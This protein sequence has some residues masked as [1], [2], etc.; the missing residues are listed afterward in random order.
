MLIS[1]DSITKYHNVKEIVK[2]ASLTIEEH[3]KTALIGVN[4][5][6][7]TTILRIVA[8]LESY[9]GNIVRKNGLRI[10][11]LPQDPVFDEQESILYQ[12]MRVDPKIEEYEAKSIL[13][14]LGMHDVDLCIA[15]LSGGQRKR[16]ALARALL[17][18]CDLLILDE[19]TNHLDNEMIEWLE[20]YLKRFSNAI[21]MV[22]HD[23]Y[24]LE[25]VCT[26]MVEISQGKLY[27]YEANY[28][29]YLEAKALREE[30]ALANEKKRQNLLRKELAWIRAGVQAR[31]TKSKERIE[32]FHALNAQDKLQLEKSIALD[33]TTS[34]LGKKIIELEHISKAYGERVLF[35][36]FSYHFTRHDRIG[37]L[38]AN[39]CGKTTL[40]HVMA[41]QLEPDS[42]TVVHGE[43][44]KLAYFKQGHGDMDGSMK[45]IDYIQE[46][47]NHIE[48]TQ[49]SY[50][51]ASMLERFLFPRS[52]HH[53]TIERLSGG[54]KR[55][56]YL[57]KV[58]MQAP[59]VLF[60]D[61]PTNDLDIATL[62]ILE[63]YLDEFNGAVVVV[64]HDRYFLDRIC[65]KLFVFQNGNIVQHIGG[66]SSF[67]QIASQT[68]ETTPKSTQPKAAVLMKMTT[69]EKQ[70]LAGMETAMDQVQK[71]IDAIDQDMEKYADDFQ[72]L[73]EL[74]IQREA[75]EKQLEEMMERWLQL[76][77]KKARI[78]AMLNK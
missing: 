18:P 70:E 41:K 25:R 31:G 51:A 4:G 57:L 10:S 52:M 40:L 9:E 62:Q 66:Y 37:I 63:D 43:T 53:T 11:Y 61:E 23:R 38:G 21:F 19:P 59:N 71:C 50:T 39:G 72:K 45:L 47:S 64:S 2:E 75:K 32:R 54:E 1:M 5:A 44:L 77:D 58:L 30:Q 42:G 7:K 67:I 46:T 6:G 22:T 3:D 55:R 26:K 16:V 20:K 48:T 8:G 69:K 34:R 33:L 15:K 65:D 28:S 17:K 13:G 29:Q 68:V 76:S 27:T 12:V 36:D 73:Q 24:F 78:D 56:L 14:K 74:S 60:L 49:R 35:R